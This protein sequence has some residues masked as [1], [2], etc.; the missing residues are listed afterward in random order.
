[1]G[2]KGRLLRATLEKGEI[3]KQFGYCADRVRGYASKLSAVCD[4]ISAHDGKTLVL[5]QLQQNSWP[6]EASLSASQAS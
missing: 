2:G 5:I 4:D 3:N 1:M 6:C